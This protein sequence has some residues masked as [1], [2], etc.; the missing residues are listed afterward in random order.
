VRK[1]IAP[2][3]RAYFLKQGS[4]VFD[5][6]FSAQ[7]LASLREPLKPSSPALLALMRRHQ[8]GE[9]AFELTG[10][11]TLRISKIFTGCQVTLEE[12]ECALCFD[13]SSGA[14][15]YSHLPSLS[16][17]EADYLV[18]V[19]TPKYLDVERHPTIYRRHGV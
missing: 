2:E 14:L 4:I 15:T 11:E 5:A 9:I 17:E 16:L 8:L 6:Q 18:I 3:H 19:L 13:L 7:E 12:D 10:H 1:T